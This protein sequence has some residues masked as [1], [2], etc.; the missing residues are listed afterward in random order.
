MDD[1]EEFQFYPLRIRILDLDGNGNPEILT[2]VN[3][4]DSVGLLSNSRSYDRCHLESRTLKNGIDVVLNWKTNALPGRISDFAVADI[5]GDGIK[6]LVATT[7]VKEGTTLF[8][9]SE[10]R[11]IAYDLNTGNAGKR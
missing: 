7:V 1:E 4:D 10:S 9:R 2:A 5:D 11:L 6:E 8:S 3:H